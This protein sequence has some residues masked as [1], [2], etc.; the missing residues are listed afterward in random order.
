MEY[1][2]GENLKTVIKNNGTF[3]VCDALNISIQIGE[4]LAYAHNEGMIHR[5]IKPSNIMVTQD[6]A[7][8]VLD[9]GLVQLPG[10]T[11]VTAPGSVVGTPE[12]MSP[13][14]ITGKDVDLR[15]D[16]YSFGVTMYEMLSGEPPFRSAAYEEIVM[17]HK[18]ELPPLLRSK[19]LKVPVKLE[20][21]VM[22]AMAKEVSQRYQNIQSILDDIYAFQKIE[23]PQGDRTII[24][25]KS[26]EK[27]TLEKT[28]K[29][30]KSF[31]FIVM[32][33]VI[34]GVFSAPVIFREKIREN[35]VCQRMYKNIAA[36]FSQNVEKEFAGDLAEKTE[37]YFR[38]LEEADEHYKTALELFY[39]GVLN[40][41][42]KEYEKAISLR[43]DCALYYK[44]LA[45]AYEK[46]G[47]N[48]NALKA[49]S[50]WKEVRG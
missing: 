20:S 13:E 30:K 50:K 41:A 17:K 40:K 14:Q 27:I 16:V 19:N 26:T 6:G 2:E 43:P 48:K 4:A 7:I 23:N 35:I 1:I 5:D 29:E 25:S 49:R 15:T 10:I 8:K 36:L 34:I 45:R 33:L 38:K 31:T 47:D 3:S 12:Y 22:K 37:G 18:Y 32:M 28:Q 46:K 11:R 39:K 24:T 44:D 21:I 9:F 42:I